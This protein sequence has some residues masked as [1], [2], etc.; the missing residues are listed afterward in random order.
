MQK[1]FST[2]V[3]VGW[4]GRER[5]EDERAKMYKKERGRGGGMII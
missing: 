4:Y 2:H 5:R 1:V 3:L